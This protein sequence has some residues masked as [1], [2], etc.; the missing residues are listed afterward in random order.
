MPPLCNDIGRSPRMTRAALDHA[1]AGQ[2]QLIAALHDAGA[3]RIADRLLRCQ[4]ARLDRRGEA[5][6]AWPWRCGGGGCWACRRTAMR[7]SW[8]RLQNWATDDGMPSTLMAVPPAQNGD[9]LL[10]MTI[11][12]RRRIRDLRD[13]AAR[14]HGALSHVAV[15]G[16]VSGDGSALLLMQH[17]GVDRRWTAEVFRRGLGGTLVSPGIAHPSW[18]MPVEQAVALAL[19]KRGIEP[20]RIVVMPQRRV[21]AAISPTQRSIDPMPVIV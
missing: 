13:R 10:A 6:S 20:L 16:M 18:Q 15:A 19:A 2:T 21:L 12:L 3:H 4:E 9:Q 1:E 8:F 7:R 5:T 14:H 11:R 17:P